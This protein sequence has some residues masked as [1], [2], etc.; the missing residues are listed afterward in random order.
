MRQQQW[1]PWLRTL[2]EADQLRP[3]TARAMVFS[4]DGTQLASAT[5]RGEVK[6]WDVETGRCRLTAKAGEGKRCPW[7]CFLPHRALLATAAGIA[8]CRGTA[9]Q[10]IRFWDTLHGGGDTERALDLGA[11]F[12]AAAFLPDGL[13]L[14]AADE[15]NISV[16]AVDSGSLLHRTRHRRDAPHALACASTGV[17]IVSAHR[18]GVCLWRMGPDGLTRGGLVRDRAK[19]LVAFRPRNGQRLA[20]ARPASLQM[21]HI[22]LAGDPPQAFALTYDF[23]D[24]IVALP[25]RGGRLAVASR[26]GL[27]VWDVAKGMSTE[28][29]IRTFKGLDQN[30]VSLALSPDGSRVASASESGLKIWD[31][32]RSGGVGPDARNDL[33]AP[34]DHQDEVCAIEVSADGSKM[35]SA[36]ADAVLVWDPVSGEKRPCAGAGGARYVVLSHGGELLALCPAS[37]DAVQIWDVAD[38]PVGEPQRLSSIP[39]KALATP[40]FSRDGTRIAIMTDSCAPRVFVWRRCEPA[41]PFVYE[42]ALDI[43]TPEPRGRLGPGCVAFAAEEHCLAAS[44]GGT[45]TIWDLLQSDSWGSLR[46]EPGTGTE[47]PVT[48]LR[49]SPC[50]RWVAA[51]FGGASIMV[52]DTKSTSPADKYLTTLQMD[53]NRVDLVAFVEADSSQFR[54]MTNTGLVLFRFDEAKGEWQR[55][56]EGYG[57]NLDGGWITVGECDTNVLQLPP[58][59]R[60]RRAT[61]VPRTS[62]NGLQVG[63]VVLGTYSG[64]IVA[65]SFAGGY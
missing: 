9:G 47:A 49:I 36:S 48:A 8:T 53:Q 2:A 5:D 4:P 41:E 64:R 61:V 23:L 21:G 59:Y 22:R 57:I 62:Q 1:S 35:V 40:S 58:D 17:E 52:W 25:S 42:L 28:K 29:R 65:L 45:I 33:V 3:G 14:A 19:S 24:A 12:S 20:V 51:S 26:D 50:Q 13:K 7:F 10:L 15:E 39:H 60:P 63:A 38:V 27:D 31:V 32:S 46:P 11:A 34:R 44:L 54:F 55:S 56:R 43:G 18:S 6:V 16:W 30:F 37:G